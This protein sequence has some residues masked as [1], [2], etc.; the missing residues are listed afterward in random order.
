MALA[1]V[2]AFDGVTKERVEQMQREIGEGERPRDIP[3]TEI[4]MLHEPETEKSLVIL[5]FETE[6]D[7]RRADEA[8]NAM[9]PEETPGR[10]ASVTKY[11]V[12]L[13]MKA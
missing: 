11:D 6:D 4:V 10:R 7:Y 12:A 1:R 5:F 3:A 8:L 13:R 2:V 9:S